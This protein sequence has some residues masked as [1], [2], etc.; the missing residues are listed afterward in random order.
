MTDTC[1]VKNLVYVKDVFFIQEQAWNCKM[2]GRSI[3]G[4]RERKQNWKY[5]NS[6]TLKVN[7]Y[8]QKSADNVINQYLPTKEKQKHY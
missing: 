5:L 6:Q 7:L 8:L 4:N 2:F 3:I 1:K